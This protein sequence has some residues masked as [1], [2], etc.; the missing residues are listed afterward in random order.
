MYFS[1]S[2]HLVSQVLSPGMTQKV[3]DNNNNIYIYKYFK[4]KLLCNGV[5]INGQ[6]S[7]LH[8]T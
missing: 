6:E 8:K 7:E 1:V 4:N 2:Y 3:K 5:L